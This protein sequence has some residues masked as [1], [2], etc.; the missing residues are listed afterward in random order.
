MRL[1]AVAKAG[2]YPTPP[3]VVERLARALVGPEAARG[4]TVR[5]LDPCCGA[6]DAA[7]GLATALHAEAYGIEL[8]AERAALARQRLDQ[9]LCASAFATRVATGGFSLLFSNPPYDADSQTRRLE[10]HFL[11]ALSRTLCPG[12]VLVYVVPRVRLRLSARYLASQYTDLSV[13]RFPDPEYDAFGQIVLLGRRK[14]KATLEPATE[15]RIIEVAGSGATNLAPLPEALDPPYSVPALPA[16][17]VLFASIHFDLAQAELEAQR[18]GVLTQAALAEQ[19]WPREDATVRPLLPLRKGHLALLI[20]AGLLN[21]I[22]LV[23]GE[24][25]VLVKGRSVKELVEVESD[26]PTVQI[27][28]EVVR[29]AITVLDLRTGDVT[30]VGHGDGNIVGGA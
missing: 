14:A 23:Q 5:L 13:Y 29:T 1:E 4:H 28:R 30:R 17:E 11:T 18:R 8:N 2:H 27:E 10:H 20:A 7:A 22:A 19:L 15:R 12:G 25:R 21:N 9:V 3:A 6:G 24:D 26:D 16:R